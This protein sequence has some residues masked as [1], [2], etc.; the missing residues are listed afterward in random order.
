MMAADLESN[1]VQKELIYVGTFSE[2]GSEGIYVFDFDRKAN[3]YNLL[4]TIVS[5]ESPSFIAVSPDGK[6]LVSVNREGLENREQWGSV[7]LFEIDQSSGR[8]THLQDQFSYGDSPCHVSFHPSGKFV[9]ISHYRGGNFVVLPILG[10]GKFGDPTANVQLK[11]KGAIM[12]RQEQP[13]TH[14]AVPSSD[15]KYLYVSDLGLDKILIYSFDENSGIVT[16]ST[17]PYVKT[18]PGAGPRHFTFSP[19]GKLAFSAEE[20]S[21]TIVSY[22]VDKANGSLDSVQR[23]STLPTTFEGNNSVADI[24]TSRK[25]KLVYISNRGF[26]GLAIYKV[27]KD[28]ELTAVDFVKTIGKKPRNFLVEPKGEYIF[29]ANRDSNSINIFKVSDDGRPQYT[30]I[31]LSVPAPVCL[32]FLKIK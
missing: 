1:K 16:S 3:R 27:M 29:V 5:K 12:P 23:L 10:N 14:S 18:S 25:G 6:F 17:Q 22:K 19:N 11:G 21:S 2:N 32:K 4:Q 15:G 31:E 26:D 13:H 20:M 7:S 8:L 9:F 30:D 28:G 24:H